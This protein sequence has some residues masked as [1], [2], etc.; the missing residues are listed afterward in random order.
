MARSTRVRSIS[1]RDVKSEEEISPRHPRFPQVTISPVKEA[2]GASCLGCWLRKE[3]NI[4][5]RRQLPPN[6][7]RFSRQF[8]SLNAEK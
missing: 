2:Q 4:P 7:P 5:N 3:D 6:I 1:N 8:H